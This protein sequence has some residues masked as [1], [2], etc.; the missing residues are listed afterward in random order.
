MKYAIWIIGF[1]I[2]IAVEATAQQIP[3][4]SSLPAMEAPTFPYGKGPVVMIDEA[5]FNFHTAEGRYKAF[6]ELL[7]RDGYTIRRSQS[8]FTRDS[9]K[10]GQVLVICNALAKRNQED[11]SLPTPSAFSDDEI[12]AVHDWVKEGGSLLLIADH[13]PMPGA[14]A[15]LA[16][17][18][19]V[20]FNN[21]FAYDTKNGE[22]VPGT[23]IFRRSG[24][25][26]VNHP[27]TN[28][29]TNRER[30]DSVAT[31][32]GQAFRSDVEIQPLLILRDSAVSLMPN[33]AWKFTSET[34]RIS[35]GGWLQGGVMRSGKGR[36]AFFGEA[37]MFTAQLAGPD[38]HP[39]GMNRPEASQNP[40]FLLNVVHWLCG[41]VEEE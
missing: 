21:G 25:S 40:Q 23:M 11:W 27:I 33:V 20:R 18:F 32:T 8:Q 5:H 35:V 12:S 22:I 9:L 2:S 24:G 28:G 14:A 3:E 7:R 38:L 30:V 15:D 31:F 17:A 37:A 6:A 13:M 1:G 4:V 36:V 39:M 19:G 10:T 29:R 26:L 41:F 16:L 34:P